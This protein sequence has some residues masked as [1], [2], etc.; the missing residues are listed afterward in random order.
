MVHHMLAGQALA[1]VAAGSM[2]AA[3]VVMECLHT[4]VDR[5]WAMVNLCV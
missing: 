1:S 5:M 2:T 3:S 4:S